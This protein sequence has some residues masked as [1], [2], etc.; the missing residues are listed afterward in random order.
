MIDIL[1]QD[2][3]VLI[4]NKPSGLISIQ[5]GYDKT[6]PHVRSILEP[7]YPHLFIVH[8]LDKNTVEC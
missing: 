7:E 1:Y 3:S 5:D 6:L 4:I 8:R 2:D